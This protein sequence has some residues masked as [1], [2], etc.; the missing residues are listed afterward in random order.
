M[1]SAKLTNSLPWLL[2][3][4]SL[5]KLSSFIMYISFLGQYRC[6]HN[7]MCNAMGS[8]NNLSWIYRCLILQ[9]TKIFK[10]M[11]IFKLMLIK[12]LVTQVKFSEVA[13][14]LN[15]SVLCVTLRLSISQNNPLF[16]CLYL[17]N[18]W[19]WLKV[20]CTEVK[21]CYISTDHRIRIVDVYVLHFS[22]KYEWLKQKMESYT[23]CMAI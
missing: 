14:S 12:W 22:K 4:V 13:F 21:L 5:E 7:Y 18:A 10:L 8:Q 17:W 6:M 9:Y 1:C 11:P 15:L 19:L 2:L 16:R 3:A 20:A 23:V